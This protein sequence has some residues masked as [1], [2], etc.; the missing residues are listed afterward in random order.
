MTDR[1]V[2]RGLWRRLLVSGFLGAGTFLATG[3][4]TA[5]VS[6]DRLRAANDPVRD[7]GVLTETLFPPLWKAVG[8]VLFGA[9]SISVQAV[10]GH[11]GGD[12]VLVSL[13]FW[14][15]RGETFPPAVPLTP[16]SGGRTAGN[17]VV[18]LF[19]APV[20]Y[21]LFGLPPL[22]LVAAGALLG[23]AYARTYGGGAV[24][25]GWLALGYLPS[26]VLLTALTRADISGYGYHTTVGVAPV[27]AILWVGVAYPVVIGG[28]GGLLSQGL[29]RDLGEMVTEGDS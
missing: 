22:A 4:V 5:V 6:Y 17:L 19:D 2:S 20:T 7:V 23:R 27:D 15:Y 18:I 26:A 9:H 3:L 28:F 16:G 13:L 25:G 10:S 11:G 14:L 24:V 21:G 1:I 12:D 8:W 29:V